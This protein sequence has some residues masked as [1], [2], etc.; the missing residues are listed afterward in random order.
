MLAAVPDIFVSV[1]PPLPSIVATVTTKLF[2]GA[3]PPNAVPKISNVS[4]ILQPEPPPL[5]LTLY[6]VPIRET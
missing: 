5:I 1:I 6:V 4:P 2:A 3:V